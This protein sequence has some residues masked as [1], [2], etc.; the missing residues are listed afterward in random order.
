MI[1]LLLILM[2]N[3]GR[4]EDRKK[5]KSKKTKQNKTKQ[6]NKRKRKVC[7]LDFVIMENEIRAA[8]KHVPVVQKMAMRGAIYQG[9]VVQT[10]DTAIHR[11]NHQRISNRKTNCTI[12]W[13]EIYPLDIVI[14]SASF[15][16]LGSDK[17]LYSG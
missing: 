14:L 4:L 11:I 3:A 1:Q 13:I 5:K 9:P 15:E 7:P 2:T 12:P 6:T 10:L 17:S 16:Q 8:S